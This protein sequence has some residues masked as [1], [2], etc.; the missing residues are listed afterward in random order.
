MS[1]RVKGTIF[2][3][4]CVA[5][6]ALIPVVAKM[7]QT[8]LDNH[9]FLFWSS[10]VS[11][12]VLSL[13]AIAKGNIAEITTY[14]LKRMDLFALFRLSGNLC[15]LPVSLSRLFQDR[16]NGSF[17]NPVYMAYFCPDSFTIYIKRTS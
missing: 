6:W 7:G 13:A 16:R 15:L 2:V 4:I 8:T 14:S 1:D 3:L 12:L 10:L 11:L 17:G 9:Q 5:L